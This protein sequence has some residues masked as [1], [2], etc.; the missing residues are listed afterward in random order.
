MELPNY[1]LLIGIADKEGVQG[2]KVKSNNDLEVWAGPLIDNKVAVV[3]WNRSSS[4]ATVTASWSDIGLEPGTM[5]DAKDLWAN[6]TQQS[7]SG[8][9]S[10]QLDSHACK[11]FRRFSFADVCSYCSVLYL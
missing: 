4:N 2:K 8:E 7:V 9:I 10:A 6:T 1:N 3:L 11:M 5:V